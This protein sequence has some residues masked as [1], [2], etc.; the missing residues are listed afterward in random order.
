MKK[1]NRILA[2]LLCVLILFC[3]VGCSMNQNTPE[4]N[5][6]LDTE[7]GAFEITAAQRE[8]AK[9]NSTGYA[10]L[11]AGRGNPNWIN[12]QARLAFSRLNEFAVEECQRTLD[13]LNMAGQAQLDGIGERFDQAMDPN[14]PTDSFLIA[15]ADYCV[16]TLKLNKD[17]L[18][19]ELVDGII[20]DYYPTPS[21][22]L[23]NTEKILNA[24]LQSTLYNGTDLA[25][26]TKVFPTEGGSAAIVYIFDALNH[27][28]LLKSGDKIAIATP[29]FTPYLQIPDVNN[30]GLVSVDVNSSETDNWDIPESE[31]KKLEDKSVK[32]FF[33]VNPSNP[34]SH[35]LSEKSVERLK[36][37]V[38]KNPDLIIIT[39]DVY[40]TFV[41]HF[42]TVY[43]AI[44]DNTLLVYSFSKLYGVTGWRIGLIAVHETN[45]FDRLLSELPAS[46]KKFLNEEYSIVTA[47]PEKL[48]FIERLVADSRSIGLYHTSGLS[49]PQQIFMDLLA[50]THL[51][52]ENGDAYIQLA[53]NTVRSRYTA[54][55]TALNM[56]ADETDG[57]AQYYALIDVFALAE[58]HYGSDFAAWFK[59]NISDLQFLQDLAEKKGVVLMYG[60]GFNA[61]QGKARI[62]L[63]NLNEEDYREIA[64][65]IFELMNEYQKNMK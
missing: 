64:R 27:N 36:Q 14:D 54:L 21:R 59:E 44:P 19:K 7:M 13:R 52:D 9:T 18:I 55:M 17:A 53:N 35:A 46:D 33:L 34:A 6:Q 65:R 3:T 49:T 42:R 61:P 31:F 23:T 11:D 47:E 2:L 39:D 29:I 10:V 51:I 26:E 45:V 15:A 48:P 58:K 5:Q 1:T 28:R 30:Y 24:Y 40:G 56:P 41:N 38:E 12:T 57:N 43:S 20:G 60:P 62:S 32:A 37:V 63:A 4:T 16:N 25:K 8:A 22:C 50:L